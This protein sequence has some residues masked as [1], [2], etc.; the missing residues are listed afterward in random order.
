[1]NNQEIAEV[2][3]KRLTKINVLD[4][5]VC[6]AEI[7]SVLFKLGIGTAV[8]GESAIKPTAEERLMGIISTC[9][10]KKSHKYPESI[11]FMAG[12]KIIFEQDKR[13]RT[14]WCSYPNLWSIFVAEYMM[15]HNAIQNLI[16]DNLERH[17]KIKGG[18]IATDT[19]NVVIRELQRHLKTKGF[20][21]IE[22]SLRVR[23]N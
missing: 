8:S 16:S 20:T 21:V 10:T 19:N 4:K 3:Y 2:I 14:F 22:G 6:K 11:F 13:L 17:L 5:D 7:A 12:D 1:M 9:T 15:A 23:A 18:Y